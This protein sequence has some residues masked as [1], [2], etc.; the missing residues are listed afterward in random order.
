MRCDDKVPRTHYSLSPRQLAALFTSWGHKSQ[1][2]SY[3]PYAK[4]KEMANFL[5]KG[6]SP[7]MNAIQEDEEDSL[8]AYNGTLQV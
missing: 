8:I 4:N 1:Q 7:G 3:W 2:L 5:A 6:Y